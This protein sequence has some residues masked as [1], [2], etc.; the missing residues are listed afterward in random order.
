MLFLSP[1]RKFVPLNIKFI[2]AFVFILSAV[3]ANAE[4]TEETTME[5]SSE[6]STQ[7]SEESTGASTAEPRIKAQYYSSDAIQAI[8]RLKP[9]TAQEPE[10]NKIIFQLKG[11]PKNKDIVLEIKRLASL[12]PKAYEKKFSFTIQQD[13]SMLIANSDQKLRAII[14]SSRG[15][16][17]GERVY[18]RF[19]TDDGA[20]DKEISGI[21]TPAIVKNKEGK[22]ALKAELLSV[23]PTIYQIELPVMNEGEEYELKS[24]SVGEITQAKPKYSEKT[25]FH[26]TPAGSNKGKGGDS[27]LE[28]H[29]KNGEV[30][31]I[32]LPWGSALQAYLQGVKAYSPNN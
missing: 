4:E 19:R 12:N 26:Y 23:N 18:Y 32:T 10:Y 14:S 5:Q 21:P 2:L 27:L 30:Y 7:P 1:S 3:F 17:P 24:T 11:Y 25:P 15:F 6:V 9:L 31:T 20:I 28:I 8:P 16:L 13:G 29:R 22:V